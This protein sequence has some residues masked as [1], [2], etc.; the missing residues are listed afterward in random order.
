MSSE[1]FIFFYQKYFK[2]A[3]RGIFIFLEAHVGIVQDFDT[4]KKSLYKGFYK[5]PVILTI[6]VGFRIEVEEL[7]L[8]ARLSKP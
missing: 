8:D 4:E 5:L 6:P 7:L 2:K 3:L 1:Y